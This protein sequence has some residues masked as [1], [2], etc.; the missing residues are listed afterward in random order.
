MDEKDFMTALY[1]ICRCLYE[2]PVKDSSLES[3]NF[4]ALLR[5]LELVFV[6]KKQLSTDLVNAFVK[7]LA[8]LQMHVEPNY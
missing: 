2:S 8:I 3:K 7:R 1:A 5:V 6:Q 4:L